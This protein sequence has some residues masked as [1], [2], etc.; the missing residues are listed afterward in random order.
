MKSI[1]LCIVVPSLFVAGCV[2]GADAPSSGDGEKADEVAAA[3]AALIGNTGGCNSLGTGRMEWTFRRDPSRNM[4]TFSKDLAPDQRDWWNRTDCPALVVDWV[5]IFPS[6]RERGGTAF[7]SGII[8]PSIINSATRE[9]CDLLWTEEKIM[10]QS[11]IMAPGTWNTF[12]DRTKTGCGQDFDTVP[13]FG[14]QGPNVDWFD[15]QARTR[16]ITQGFAYIFPIPVSAYMQTEGDNSC[17]TLCCYKG[18]QAHR[19]GCGDI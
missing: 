14:S 12:I 15:V 5:R 19:V 17:P 9:Q 6:P 11:S 18:N 4:Q 13:W 10:V 7:V 2:A 16:A 1:G 8:E 3:P